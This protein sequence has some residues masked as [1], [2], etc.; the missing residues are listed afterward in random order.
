MRS[1]CSRCCVPLLLL[2]DR[3]R[4]SASPAGPRSTSSA[5][6]FLTSS[7]WD[8]VKR[9]VRRRARDLRHDRLVDHRAA[10][11][12][13]ARDRRRDLPLRVRPAMAAP[14]GRA[15]SSICSPRSRASSTG[16]GGSSSSSRCFAITV[17]PFLRDTL[18][19]GSDAVLHRPGVW[20]EHARRGG[21]PRDHGA[22]VHLSRVARGA[23]APCRARSAKPRSRWA[24]R[25]G[26]RSGTP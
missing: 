20:A 2:V 13:A 17:M 16:C 18:H 26:R 4:R 15:F 9:T 7:E 14:A 5:L 3:D 21:H 19:L 22:A 11:R 8:P 10:A 23:A 6:A 24:P 1:R 12:D 25:A